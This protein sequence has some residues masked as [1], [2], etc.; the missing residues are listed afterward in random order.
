[1]DPHPPGNLGPERGHDVTPLLVHSLCCTCSYSKWWNG[2]KAVGLFLIWK[3]PS[4][5]RKVWWQMNPPWSCNGSNWL[6][7]KVKHFAFLPLEEKRQKMPC[8]L[9]SLMTSE[10]PRQIGGPVGGDAMGHLISHTWSCLLF[11]GSLVGDMLT[12]SQGTVR[13][14]IY[15]TTCWIFS[16]RRM[17][18]CNPKR[19][20]ISS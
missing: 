16:A 3:R 10:L 17:R 11:Q 18:I 1:M 20:R 14:G 8:C 5:R 6:L 19:Y 12:C 9:W 15:L 2:I 4:I 13:V 7:F